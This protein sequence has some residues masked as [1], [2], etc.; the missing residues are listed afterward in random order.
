MEAFRLIIFADLR[1]AECNPNF[2]QTFIVTGSIFINDEMTG[3]MVSAKRNGDHAF[4]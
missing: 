2:G 4:Y 1:A 3:A